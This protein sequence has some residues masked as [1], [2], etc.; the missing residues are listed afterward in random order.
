[1]RS[2]IY[3]HHDPM[4]PE[5]DGHYSY[6]DQGLQTFRYSLIP[7][8]GSW[9]EAETV[10]RAAE[11]NQ[12][13]VALISTFHEGTLPQSASYVEVESSSVLAS[14]LKQAEEGNALILRLYETS[15]NNA[16]AKI[17]L[18]FLKRS[19]E[20]EFAPCE[21]KTFRIPLDGILPVSEVNLLEF[22]LEKT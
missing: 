5:V 17:T 6:I 12:E 8:T 21:I 1:V 13:P 22:E 9:V 18:P 14:V 3:A 10:K 20:A 4:V 16:R 19:F 7:H 2:P 11:L 15:K